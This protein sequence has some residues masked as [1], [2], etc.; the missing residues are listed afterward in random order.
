M[1][2]ALHTAKLIQIQIK[3]FTFEVVAAVVGLYQVLCCNTTTIYKLPQWVP[4]YCVHALDL[5]QLLSSYNIIHATI[6]SIHAIVCILLQGGI[7]CTRTLTSN[8]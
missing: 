1:V 2:L 4:P 5:S 3:R 7:H 8:M 6:I